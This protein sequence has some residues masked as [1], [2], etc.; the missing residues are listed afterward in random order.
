MFSRH[1]VAV[2]LALLTAS[3][4][5]PVAQQP[6][7]GTGRVATW[8]APMLLRYAALF[9][10]AE[11]LR[12]S[13]AETPVIIDGEFGEQVIEQRLLLVGGADL[14]MQ[15]TVRGTLRTLLR[16]GVPTD[17]V[18]LSRSA[19]IAQGIRHLAAVGIALPAGLPEVQDLGGRQILFWERRVD[20]VRVPGDGLRVVLAASGELV[21][22]AQPAPA[23]LAPAPAEG[24]RATRA[25]ALMAAALRLPE[26]GSLDGT[27]ELAWIA[28]GRA[29]GDEPS[30]AVRRLAWVVGCE[31]AAGQSCAIRL[32]AASLDLL[33][34]D[35]TP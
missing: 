12:G 20:G 6:Q 13:I 23:P 30:E 34:W 5:A 7:G 1:S 9:V 32:D 15:V 26:G 8:S 29:G 17:E 28:A 3:C 4:T 19:L 18:S 11:A 16:S 25:A 33:G 22:I 2:T 14:T 27:A 24:A 31:L 10:D 35:W 21:G